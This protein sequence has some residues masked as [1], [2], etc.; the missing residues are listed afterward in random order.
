MALHPRDAGGGGV[1][2]R[3]H[4]CSDV[5]GMLRWSD[6]HLRGAMRHDDG[7][8]MTGREVRDS[9]KIALNNGWRV[10]PVGECEGFSYETGCPG[11]PMEDEP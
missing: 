8:P 9:L 5:R 10:I 3:H 2:T 7:R 1:K 11:H 6:R 4:L